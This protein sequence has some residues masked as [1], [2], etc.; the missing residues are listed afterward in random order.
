MP[1]ASVSFRQPVLRASM[2]LP[3]T[4][5]AGV[6]SLYAVSLK[7]ATPLPQRIGIAMSA[8]TRSFLVAGE[9]FTPVRRS[10]CK[11]A[12]AGSNVLALVLLIYLN[13]P[14]DPELLSTVFETI[15]IHAQPMTMSCPLY[16]ISCWCQS[17]RYLVSVCGRTIAKPLSLQ[18]DE[19]GIQCARSCT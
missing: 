14:D 2:A 18:W 7:N 17:N 1:L 5:T 11:T 6:A 9:P 3:A 13:R 10:A 16:T 4:M 19:I 12:A 8:D 15:T